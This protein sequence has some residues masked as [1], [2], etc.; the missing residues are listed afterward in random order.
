MRCLAS[1]ILAIALE[2]GYFWQR[3]RV[4]QLGRPR[5]LR[6]FSTTDTVNPNPSL[7]RRNSQQSLPFPGA[8]SPP[9]LVRHCLNH[10]SEVGFPSRSLASPAKAWT[11][12][13]VR[14]APPLT[15]TRSVLP[16]GQRNPSMRTS[17][18]KGPNRGT[19]RRHSP[20]PR[21]GSGRVRASLPG[22]GRLRGLVRGL[23]PLGHS[24]ALPPLPALAFRG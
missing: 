14:A 2:M 3:C 6:H 17:S 18:P 21:G 16:A 5:S 10:H 1:S 24:L 15:P 12:M 9:L 11:E 8:P 23:Q 20:A 7:I 13:Q 4:E 19:W 22:W